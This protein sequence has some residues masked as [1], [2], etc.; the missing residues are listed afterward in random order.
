[1]NLMPSCPECRA[2]LNGDGDG[3][4][5]YCIECGYRDILGSRRRR[6]DNLP[7]RSAPII[8]SYREWSR[9]ER[10][11]DRVTQLSRVTSNPV[12]RYDIAKAG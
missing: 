7:S 8:E 10:L 5:L 2:P 3:S 4:S 1:M 12:S 11:K 9:R 6:H